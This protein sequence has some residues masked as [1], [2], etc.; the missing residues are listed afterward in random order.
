[1]SRIYLQNRGGW[2]GVIVWG[3]V[4]GVSVTA[5]AGGGFW[6]GRVSVPS[7]LM[8]PQMVPVLEAVFKE[9]RKRLEAARRESQVQ[10]DIFAGRVGELQAEILRLNAL[11]GRLVEMA[12]LDAEE[13][14]F[15]N[16]PPLGG[17]A[18]TRATNTIDLSELL[19]GMTDLSDLINDRKPKLKQLERMIMERGLGKHAIPSGW[20]VRS[21]YIT[22]GFGYRMHPI[23]KKYHLHSGVDFAGKRGTPIFA[24]A[25]GVVISSG[26]ESGYGRIVKIRHM[27]GLVTCYAH[28]QKNLVKKGDLVK[29]GQ[30]IAK[31]GSSGRSTGPHVH[32]EVRRHGKAINPMNYVGTKS[33]RKGDG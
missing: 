18:D 17:P 27:D 5:A 2:K 26:W 29:K 25:D 23:L 33:Y 32:F 21:G 15:E 14:D 6:Y 28:N 20:P 12:G 4:L 1:M 31:L 24:T 19:R 13:F 7:S 3:I 10:L 22:S 16:S 9:E 30:M 11:G 8:S